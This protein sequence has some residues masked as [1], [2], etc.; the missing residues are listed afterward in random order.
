MLNRFYHYLFL[1]SLIGILNA[2]RLSAESAPYSITLSLR[3]PDA[4]WKVKIVEIRDSGKEW[5]VVARLN[6]RPGPASQT[7]TEVRDEV[8][9]TSPNRPLKVF[10][11]GKTWKWQ[12]AE[13]YV[14]VEKEAE[15]ESRLPKTKIAF[16]RK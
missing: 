6:R 13:P 1:F 14:F 10:V 4:G 3:A 9:V 7:I 8:I 16:S 12:N 2:D 11:L 15:L 5:W